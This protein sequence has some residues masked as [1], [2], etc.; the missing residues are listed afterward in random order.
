[1]QNDQAKIEEAMF[2]RLYSRYHNLMYYAAMQILH[3]A[4]D[5]EDAVQDS[6]LALLAQIQRVSGLEESRAKTLCVVVV[7]HKAID[8]LRK[9]HRRSEVCLD[10][11]FPAPKMSSSEETPAAAA[12]NRINP[13]YREVLLLYYD[14]GLSSLEI[15]QMLRITKGTALKLL[16]RARN[17]LERELIK[18]E[19][20]RY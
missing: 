5:A 15:S 4:E 8:L 12:L 16:G 14:I 20:K 7:R 18:D 1:M 3:N 2:L 9:R 17:A 11:A 13:R 19:Y 10:E 6:F